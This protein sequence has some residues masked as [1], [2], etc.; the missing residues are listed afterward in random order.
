MKLIKVKTKEG[1]LYLLNNW[2]NT[3][4]NG[5]LTYFVYGKGYLKTKSFELTEIELPERYDKM[6]WLQLCR[7]HE[8][9]G[10]EVSLQYAECK[11]AGII[12]RQTILGKFALYEK[13]RDIIPENFDEFFDIIPCDY[14]LSCFGIYVLDIIG[15]DDKLSKIDPEYN[16]IELK[17]KG[18]TCSM[19][20]YITMKYGEN[21]RNI[22][23]KLI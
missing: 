9:Y 3:I 16:N 17:Y 15:L 8:Q 11:I 2:P 4:K 22:V 23:E 18:V 7:I 6:T 14:M 10:I 13:I 1:V 20:E 5:S 12:A 19:S 21:Y